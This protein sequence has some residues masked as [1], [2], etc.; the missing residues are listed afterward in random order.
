VLVV[1]DVPQNLALLTDFL[2]VAGFDVAQAV[3]GAQALQADAFRP[4]LILMDNVMPVMTGLEATRRLRGHADFG[5]V[6]I[7][8]LRLEWMAR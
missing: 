5:G 7:D 6:P 4:D 8:P 2:C 3:N 1:D